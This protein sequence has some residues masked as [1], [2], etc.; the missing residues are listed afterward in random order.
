VL[1]NLHA[2]LR[3]NQRKRIVRLVE[4]SFALNLRP[5]LPPHLDHADLRQQCILDE[6]IEHQ[7]AVILLHEDVIDVIGLLLG[8]GHVLRSDRGE[9]HHLITAR[10]DLH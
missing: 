4:I 1:Y 9:P 10:E 8:R 6:G 2:R 7:E 3:D 5:A